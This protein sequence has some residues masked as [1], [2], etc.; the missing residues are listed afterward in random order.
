MLSKIDLS[1][2]NLS[3]YESAAEPY[4]AADFYSRL[5]LMKLIWA[6]LFLV[7]SFQSVADVAT[8]VTIESPFAR[9]ALKS[10]RNSA[11]FMQVINNGEQAAIKQASSAAAEVVELHTHTNDNGV[12]RMRQIPEIELPANST[13]ELRP[14][15]LHVMLI[16]LQ[17]DLKVGDEV[18]VTL[19][20][21]DGSQRD[22]SAEVH[23]VM[24]HHKPMQKK[25][26]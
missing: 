15:G 4:Y 25:Q 24:R 1:C 23:K 16:G 6:V 19:E 21:N 14:G 5:I 18:T 20:F 11:V 8:Q 12:M 22:V 10:Q 13:V 9:A 26:H 2:D 7:W 17:R 3:L